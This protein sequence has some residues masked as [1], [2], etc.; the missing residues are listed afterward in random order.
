M[1]R[2][3]ARQRACTDDDTRSLIDLVGAH[4]GAAPMWPVTA[5]W[6]WFLLTALV[7]LA[8]L[9]GLATLVVQLTGWSA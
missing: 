1:R 3:G 6:G 4:P 5:G 7:T 8:V 9:A 2:T